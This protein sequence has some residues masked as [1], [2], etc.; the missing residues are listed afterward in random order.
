MKLLR[1]AALI[2][3]P[4]GA[5]GSI[6]LFLRVALAQRTPPLLLVMFIVWLVSPFAVL[7][8]AHLA[9]RRWSDATRTALNGVTI[10][11]ALASLA[12]YS[13]LIT[14]TPH[15]SPKAAPFVVVAPTS[16]LVIASVVPLAALAS[17]RR[18]S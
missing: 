9:S 3:M 1:T 10:V 11:I 6:W 2:A 14:V 4:A 12:I 15:G 18:R 16:W 13:N 17:T 5:V 7:G 8:W